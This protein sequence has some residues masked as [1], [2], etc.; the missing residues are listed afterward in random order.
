MKKR[1]L[2]VLIA[3]F[4]AFSPVNSFAADESTTETTEETTA[5]Q[6]QTDLTEQFST[7]ITSQY[8]E[9]LET[10]TFDEAVEK[11][12]RNSSSLNNL[13]AS[14]D[15]AETQLEIQ[16]LEA[17]SSDGFSGLISFLNSQSSYQNS[18]LSIVAQ[19]ESVKHSMKESYIN[20]I[21]LQR[22]IALSEMALKNDEYNLALS[23]IKLSNGKISQSEYDNLNLAYNT[24]KEQL[25]TQKDTLELEY[26][27]LNILMGTDINK[28]YNFVMDAVYE[29]FELDI[30]VESYINGKVASSNSVRQAEKS[31]ETS[32][33]T[34]KLTP[35]NSSEIGG[36]QSAQNSLNSAEM[37]YEDA[38]N[39]VYE[40]LY[41]K[42]N[43]IVQEEKNYT[44]GLDELKLLQD[45][46]ERV[47]VKYLSGNASYYEL[48]TAQYNVAE[49]ENTLLSSVYSHMLLSEELTNTELM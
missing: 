22:S 41:Q 37:S 1:Y 36:Y 32:K 39:S 29:P 6:E 44:S 7:F 34:S 26:V 43:S 47:Q 15:L 24:A 19:E 2:A 12:L 25:E 16:Y 3:V 49:K 42:Y 28:R 10:L 48:L 17:Y 20:I 9:D 30:P 31:Y 4:M 14:M 27:S 33:Q 5:E 13:K 40:S 46:F 23:K 45:E 11:A 8:D 21:E 18:E 35:L 38:K